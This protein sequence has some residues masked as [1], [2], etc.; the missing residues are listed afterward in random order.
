M[1]QIN[2]DLICEFECSICFN[3]MQPPMNM[4]P[5]GHLYCCS[6]FNKIDR[7]PMCRG[8]KQGPRNLRLER[9]FEKLFFP[10]KYAESG[11]TFES[12][13]SAIKMHEVECVRKQFPCPI[14]LMYECTWHGS[15]LQLEQHAKDDHRLLDDLTRSYWVPILI[16]ERCWR[17]IIKFDEALFLLTFCG[18]VDVLYVGV[19]VLTSAS[20]KTYNYEFTFNGNDRQTSVAGIC[21]SFNEFAIHKIDIDNRMSFPLNVLNKLKNNGKLFYRIN[22]TNKMN[23][24]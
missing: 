6:C 10:C 16:P 24:I 5:K 17:D 2:Y 21:S 19:Y 14:A 8:C 23:L 13:G 15:L 4:C 7:C 18:D 1:S 3:Y 12:L 22:I 9:L 20:D 11:C